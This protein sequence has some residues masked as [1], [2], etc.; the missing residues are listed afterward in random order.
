MGGVISW[1]I[2][3]AFVTIVSVAGIVYDYRKKRLAVDLLREAVER[4]TQLDP[5]VL[6]RLLSLQTHAAAREQV[7]PQHLK[8]GGIITIAS[9]AGFFVLALFMGQLA[10]VAI[11]PIMA[12]GALAICVG[13][14]LLISARIIEPDRSPK[15]HGA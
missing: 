9:G 7:Q 6:D 14:G 10:H 8:I 3:W 11:Y 4:G 5:T 12:V 13:I 15:D 1:G 2:F